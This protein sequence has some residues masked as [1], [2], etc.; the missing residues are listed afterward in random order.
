ME[1]SVPLL[2]A[3]E[4]TQTSYPNNAAPAPAPAPGPVPAP[5]LAPP[6]PCSSPSPG[7]APAPA[8]APPHL[9]PCPSPSPAPASAPAPPQSQSQ[10]VPGSLLS[11]VQHPTRGFASPC[12]HPICSRIAGSPCSHAKALSP[13]TQIWD[14]RVSN[15]R[16]GRPRLD[17]GLLRFCLFLGQLDLTNTQL[18]PATPLPPPSQW[19]GS[20]VPLSPALVDPGVALP[21]STWQDGSE[22]SQ[23]AV[24][25]PAQ[26][27]QD[28]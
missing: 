17:P 3:L 2:L 27:P 5:A 4:C 6:Q 11:Q 15:S 16:G 21:G 9:S 28:G 12:Y 7:P 8:P 26:S 19:R 25:S 14:C 18:G 20:D 22:L 13:S 1:L 10:P 24:S 23:P